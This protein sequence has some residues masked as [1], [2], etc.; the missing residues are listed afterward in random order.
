MLALLTNTTSRLGSQLRRTITHAQQVVAQ[1]R[2]ARQQRQLL[3]N[4]RRSVPQHLHQDIGLS[5]VRQSHEGESLS[6][7]LRR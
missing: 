5:D 4:L 1:H 3:D 6:Q 2:A 7:R